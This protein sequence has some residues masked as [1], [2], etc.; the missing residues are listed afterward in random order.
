MKN[1]FLIL[2][3]LLLFV[4][5]KESEDPTSPNNNSNTLTGIWKMDYIGNNSD[6]LFVTLNINGSNNNLGGNGSVKYTQTISGN[7]RSAE[8]SGTITGT[9]SDSTLNASISSFN[10]NGNKSGSNYIGTVIYI[11]SLPFTTDTLIINN[12]TLVKQ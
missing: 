8:G 10:F 5:C 4:G 2:V 1:L 3:N 9:Y 7:Y 6:T 11:K 12:A